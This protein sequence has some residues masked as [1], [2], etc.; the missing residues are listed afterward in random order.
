MLLK[1]SIRRLESGELIKIV[2]LGDS[3]T[4]GWMVRKGYIDF[5]IEMLKKKYPGGNISMLNQGIPGDTAEGGLHRLGRDVIDHDPHL[6]FIQFGLNDAYSG[7]PPGEFKNTIR[8]IVE[9]ISASTE[10]EI[11]LVTSVPVLHE[12]EDQLAE[13]FY[14]MIIEVSREQAVPVAQVH[15]YW[16]K[17]IAGGADF[18]SLVQFDGVHPTVEGYRL[19]AEAIMEVL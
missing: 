17:K 6:V 1:E 8:R 5:I 16:K 3:L 19:M 18:S 11:L 4:Q 13:R 7:V 14:N 2:A 12:S 15:R 10:A 9:G